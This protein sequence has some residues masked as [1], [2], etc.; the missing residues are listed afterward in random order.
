MTKYIDIYAGAETS[1]EDFVQEVEHLLGL[2]ARR[3]QDTYIVRYELQEE[4]TVFIVVENLF[5]KNDDQ[6][7]FEDYNF[8]ISVLDFIEDPTKGVS[9]QRKRANDIFQALSATDKYRLLMLYD[10]QHKL[11][12]FT[13]IS[14]QRPLSEYA[15]KAQGLPA[16]LMIFLA[17]DWPSDDIANDME[18]MLNVPVEIV[19]YA[20]EKEYVFQTSQA[21]FRLTQH[22]IEQAAK[23]YEMYPSI[24]HVEGRIARP[25]ERR[26]WQYESGHKLFEQ[27]KETGRYRLALVG[28]MGDLQLEDQDRVLAEF[29]PEGSY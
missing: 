17:T 3:I 1:L 16:W 14:Q 29:T 22:K 13:P 11:N 7:N 28:D 19:S 21:R 25:G 12:E 24:I 15:L 5:V 6:H 27:L 10:D 2:S 8:S 26:Y 4:Q 23:P 9:W 20:G 18:S